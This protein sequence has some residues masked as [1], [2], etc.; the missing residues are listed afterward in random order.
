MAAL[1][2]GS[3]GQWA[4]PDLDL[5]ELPLEALINVLDGLLVL[6]AKES[7]GFL[8]GSKEARGVEWS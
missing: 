1:V 6:A 8:E 3:V 7:A 5:L 4:Y 2:K